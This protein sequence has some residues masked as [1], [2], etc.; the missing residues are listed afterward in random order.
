MI[1]LHTQCQAIIIRL[2]RRVFSFRGDETAAAERGQNRL[3]MLTAWIE[4][5]SARKHARQFLYC[6]M[7]TQLF[8]EFIEQRFEI[9]H[10]D[11]WE[12][13][14][15]LRCKKFFWRK[16]LKQICL[17]Q[18]SI[19]ELCQ[20]VTFAEKMVSSWNWSRPPIASVNSL[21]PPLQ[22]KPRF[23]IRCLQ[24]LSFITSQKSF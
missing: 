24:K 22:K 5:I 8:Y 12:G 18:T 7:H 3:T 4:F 10:G 15:F 6:Y 13:T 23:I 19:V 9:H 20:I 21:P 16:S 17:Q 11:Q 2:P 1:L 14:L